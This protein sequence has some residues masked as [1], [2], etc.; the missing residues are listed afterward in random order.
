MKKILLYIGILIANIALFAIFTSLAY[1]AVLS[2]I[3][4]KAVAIEFLAW[5]LFGVA[6]FS[7]TSIVSNICISKIRIPK[8]DIWRLLF[9]AIWIAAMILIIIIAVSNISGTPNPKPRLCFVIVTTFIPT[10]ISTVISYSLCNIKKATLFLPIGCSL[11]A[12]FGILGAIGLHHD[13][14]GTMTWWFIFGMIIAFIG[15]AITHNKLILHTG[16]GFWINSLLRIG[17][18]SLTVFATMFI[19]FLG[20][21]SSIDVRFSI[22]AAMVITIIYI[23]VDVVLTVFTKLFTFTSNKA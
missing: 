1:S 11:V 2:K 3:L 14:G 5:A 22:V 15:N 18:T 10:L 19:G 13:T 6:F 12:L 7:L 17:I 23:V 8:A 16:N 21:A 20:T 9:N 4:S